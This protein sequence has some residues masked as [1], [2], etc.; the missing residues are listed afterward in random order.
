MHEVPV[1]LGAVLLPS[2][3]AARAWGP[4]S[5]RSLSLYQYTNKIAELFLPRAEELGLR[6]E[7]CK[8]TP[9]GISIKICLI[10]FTKMH[11]KLPK[12]KSLDF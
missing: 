9:L 10:T 8:N 3:A 2:S 6:Y 4:E 12:G 11:H 7:A 1:L 5:H